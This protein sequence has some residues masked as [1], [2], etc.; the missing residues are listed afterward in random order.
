MCTPIN[1]KLTSGELIATTWDGE[2]PT[3]EYL[4]TR[5]E[6]LCTRA[7]SLDE[8]T[9]T[10]STNQHMTRNIRNSRTIFG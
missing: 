5:S 9:S 10:L 4:S 6:S 3:S 7:S 1:H 8:D 2:L